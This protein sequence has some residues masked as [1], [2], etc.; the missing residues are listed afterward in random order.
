MFKKTFKDN[1]TF[2]QDYFKDIPL[3][4]SDVISLICDA[5]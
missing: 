1:L 5:I 3:T 2:S 4:F